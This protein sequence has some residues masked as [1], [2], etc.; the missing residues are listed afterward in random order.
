[1]KSY[2][3]RG[4][5]INLGMSMGVALKKGP[6]INYRE[7]LYSADAAMYRA[8][9]SAGNTCVFYEEGMEL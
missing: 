4:R 6:G 1:M 8:K 5:Q 7:M 3:I 2:E 9:K